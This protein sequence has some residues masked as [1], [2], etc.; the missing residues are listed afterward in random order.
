MGDF[1]PG[2]ERPA[3]RVCLPDG[4]LTAPEECLRPQC[5]SVQLHRGAM[6]TVPPPGNSA[7]HL[8]PGP[9]TWQLSGNELP[10]CSLCWSCASVSTHTLQHRHLPRGR[11][12]LCP[13]S[14]AVSVYFED[15][16]S[17]P[18]TDR[19]SRLSLLRARSLPDP[20]F[21]FPGPT[22]P[23]PQGSEHLSAGGVCKALLMLHTR[24]FSILQ[25]LSG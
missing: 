1:Q 17:P 18:N 13:V 23:C 14:A 21:S 2:R 7:H 10:F 15:L 24:S 6:R 4:L 12:L 19:M 3:A 5:L 8:S 22:E 20:D 11:L 9:G 25:S 16:S